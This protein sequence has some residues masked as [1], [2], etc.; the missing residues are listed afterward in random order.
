MEKLFTRYREASRQYPHDLAPV[1]RNFDHLKKYIS[2][3][4]EDESRHRQ[5]IIE[6]FPDPVGRSGVI[7]Y[8]GLEQVPPTSYIKAIVD[9]HANVWTR[10]MQGWETISI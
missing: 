9:A 8:E 1:Q 10:R 5:T 2:S 6:W 3:F 4:E 7:K